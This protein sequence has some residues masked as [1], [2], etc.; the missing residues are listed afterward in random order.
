MGQ[1]VRIE[2]Y[3]A[4]LTVQVSHTSGIF[5]FQSVAKTANGWNSHGTGQNSSMG[6]GRSALR[7]K[8]QNFGFV[9][10]DGLGRCQIIS[11]Q[12][13]RFLRVNAAFHN[14][15]QI[16]QNPLGD[17]PDVCSTGLHI[18]IIHGSEHSCKLL[19]GH[20][21][22][23]FRITALFL[24][25]GEN[26]FHI[27]FVFYEHGM[28]VK[29]DGN[30]FTGIFSC[31]FSQNVQLLHSSFLSLS[32]PLFLGLHVLNLPHRYSSVRAL[33]EIQLS[34]NNTLGNTFSLH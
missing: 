34:F 26:T 23:I 22:S 21:N 10:L 18:G 20:L 5:C 31:F 11:C 33:E 28:S 24:Q 15:H 12:N 30:F 29:E 13:N 25:T 6:I 27:V 8:T 4:C 19:S 16:I 9:Q 14:P 1:L 3:T 17:I 2:N 7:Y 32:K